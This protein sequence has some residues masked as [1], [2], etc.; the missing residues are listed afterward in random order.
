MTNESGDR[1]P[2]L[3]AAGLTV[4][5]GDIEVLRDIDF[6]L[7]RGDILGII[8]E[9]GAG[10]S[11][12]GRVIADQLPDGFSVTS[13]MLRFGA[14]DLI[15]MPPKDHRRLLGREIAFIPQ[16]PMMALNPSMTIGSHFEEHLAHLG[17]TPSTMRRKTIEALSDVR[18]AAPEHVYDQYP[19][20]LS[21]GMCQRVLIALAFISNPDL[22][23]ADEPTASLDVT[24][25]GHI[26]GL[27]RRMQQKHGTAVLFITHQLALAG[28]ICTEVAVLYAGEVVERGATKAVFTAPQHPYTIA[29]KAA[30]PLLDGEWTPLA[31]LRGHM[32]GL[33][34]Y[35]TL[36]GCRFAPRCATASDSCRQAT[37]PLRQK[38]DHLARCLYDDAEA[39]VEFPEGA[40]R[41]SLGQ[42]KGELL[43]LDSVSKTFFRSGWFSRKPGVNALRNVSLEIAAGEFVGI[44]GESGSGKSTLGRLVM[45][46]EDATN[47]TILLDGKPLGRSEDEWE[48]RIAAIQLVFQDPRA[49]LNPRR[50]VVDLATQAIQPRMMRAD[51]RRARAEALLRS[52]GLPTDM[53]DKVSAEMSGGQRQRVSIARA[54]CNAP[55]LL[56][57]DEVTS[58]LD[59]SVQAQIL[60]LLLN[61]RKEYGIALMMISHDLAVVR[62]LCSRVVVMWKGEIV[63]TGLTEEVFR[64]PQHRYTRELI[65]AIPPDDMNQPW[66]PLL[67][68]AKAS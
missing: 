9:S 64:N 2:L 36:D 12:I 42:S 18:I 11:M 21:G 49:A 23:I 37:V 10:K 55:R 34:E 45:G 15:G 56:I 63:E 30:A 35:R 3:R 66:L 31:S 54:L 13:G 53:L 68:F 8:G 17:H 65:S 38:S 27:L 7:H 14:L 48:R 26:I 51:A 28:Q 57:A 33:R 19:F 59:V 50:R 29:L 40:A 24:S 61:I 52:T 4:R 44:V 20:Q 39:R 16:E 22:V 67:E 6:S 41:A 5:M 32:P 46:L 47:G 1:I 58:G 60:N 25:Q 43:R 62:Y